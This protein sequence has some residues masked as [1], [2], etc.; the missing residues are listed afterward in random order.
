ME[1]FGN[2][3][4][5]AA[6]L[7]SG[8]VRLPQ[9]LAAQSPASTTSE[10][11]WPAGGTSPPS[12]PPSLPAAIP[13]KTAAA[14]KQRPF[15]FRGG[16]RRVASRRGASGPLTAAGAEARGSD[17]SRGLADFSDVSERDAA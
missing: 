10:E 1:P 6:L 7:P 9:L 4:S 11:G 5:C 2:E 3:M 17:L 15:H 14:V 13:R 16:R 8:A 12:P